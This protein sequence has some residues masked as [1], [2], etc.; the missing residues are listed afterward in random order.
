MVKHSFR[1]SY[2]SCWKCVKIAEEAKGQETFV[3]AEAV[4]PE[5]D[6]LKLKK[7]GVL[8][9][10]TPGTARS[11]TVNLFLKARTGISKGDLSNE[12]ISV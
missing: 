12:R 5:K 4:I 6:V 2:G 7:T 3:L 9:A 1:G 8:R 11:E 10:Y